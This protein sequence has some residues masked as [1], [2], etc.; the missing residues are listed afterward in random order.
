MPHI[1]CNVNP[2]S[3][4]A[5]MPAA[6]KGRANALSMPCRPIT[7]GMPCPTGRPSM[8]R[9]VLF[10]AALALLLNPVRQAKAGPVDDAVAEFNLS[11]TNP[12]AGNPWTYATETALGGAITPMAV[13]GKLGQPSDSDAVYFFNQNVVGPV[14]GKNTGATTI[15]LG[16][17]PNLLWPNSVLLIGPGG[18][19][20]PGSPEFSVVQWTAPATG[21]YNLSGTFVNLQAANTDLHILENTTS[22]Y[23]NSYNGSESGQDPLPFSL[24]NLS[25]SQGQTIQFIVGNNGAPNNFNDVVGLSAS[26]ALQSSSAP[27]PSTLI[28]L[29]IGS[30]V[31]LGYGSRQWKLAAA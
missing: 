1:V 19:N 2:F 30:V 28:L 15:N 22:I 24:P 23:S 4:H 18:G 20:N 5:H 11:G 27:E 10:L 6:R 9:S 12:L 21:L 3:G 25:L 17:S 29:G 13:F 31:L 7:P 16:G 14:I 26:I 8:K